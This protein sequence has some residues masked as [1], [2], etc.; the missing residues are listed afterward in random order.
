MD[1]QAR[2]VRSSDG[3]SIAYLRLGDGRPLVQM[4]LVPFSHIEMVPKGFEEPMRVYEVQWR[5]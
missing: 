3:V 5:V 1:P 4:P 2:Y